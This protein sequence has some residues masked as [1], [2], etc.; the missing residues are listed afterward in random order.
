MAPRRERI[1]GPVDVPSQASSSQE[2]P[3]DEGLEHGSDGLGRDALDD[4]REHDPRE[5]SGRNGSRPGSTP[6]FS[7][8]AADAGSRLALASGERACAEEAPTRRPSG[9]S[10]V[11]FCTDDDST[12]NVYL[13]Q[14]GVV[15]LLTAEEEVS[16]AKL[17][18]A[19]D[20]GARRHMIEANLRLVVS[21]ARRY[22]GR[23]LSFSDLVQEGNF[24]LMRATEK[25]DYRRGNKFSTYATWWIRQAITRALAD[26]GRTVRLP[27]HV[28]ERL[29][30]ISRTT[31][32]LRQHLGREPDLDEVAEA[33]NLAPLDLQALLDVAESPLSLD[34]SLDPDSESSDLGDIISDPDQPTSFDAVYRRLRARTVAEAIMALP[35]RERSVL[36][37]RYGLNG[38]DPWTLGEIGEYYGISRERVRQIEGKAIE[39]IRSNGLI[40]RLRETA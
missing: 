39:R 21:I 25:F 10:R 3:L 1:D 33:V 27:V 19:G 36:I 22:V 8:L 5:E 14:I 20:E 4:G 34:V 13:N 26:K 23:G 40:R 32:E 6:P 9:R 24:G 12:V 29:S 17:I 30:S 31:G 15:P 7:G 37:Y 38:D 28:V 16:L 35:E 11:Y 2:D 18:E